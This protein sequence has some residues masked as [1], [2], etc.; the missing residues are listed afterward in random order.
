M[1]HRKYL[2]LTQISLVPHLHLQLFPEKPLSQQHKNVKLSFRCCIFSKKL[3]GCESCA[4][5]IVL[6]LAAEQLVKK[7]EKERKLRTVGLIWKR[8]I[9]TM[10]KQKLDNRSKPTD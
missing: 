10:K 7:R 3:G 9:E 2:E 6:R 1:L 8:E 5:W 4:L